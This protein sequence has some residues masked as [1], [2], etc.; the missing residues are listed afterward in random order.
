MQSSTVGP[1]PTDVPPA[2]PI[3]LPEFNPGVPKGTLQHDSLVRFLQSLHRP[4]ELRAAHFEALGIQ[5]H[6]EAPAE[7]VVPDAS[8]LPP[9]SKE[10]ENLSS[11]QA[12]AKDT[13]FRLDLSNGNKSPEARVYA[14][15]RNEL[16]TDN[17][18]AFRTIRRMR[19]EPGA[20]TPRLGHCYDFFTRLE[21]MASYWDDTSLPTIAHQ[22]E[23]SDL[24][25]KKTSS[26]SPPS[27]FD[28]GLKQAHLAMAGSEPLPVAALESD[29]RS[30]SKGVEE[31]SSWRVT[32]RTAAGSA[33]PPELRHGVISAFIK[34]VSYDFGC[35]ITAPRAE[36]RLHL[37]EPSP[38]HEPCSQKRPSQEP[39][40]SYFNSGCVFLARVPTKREAAR[41]GIVEGPL[42]AVSAR[43]TTSFS[44]PTENNVD[45]GR[46]IVAALIT[47]QHRAR[48]GKEERR[49]G[50][51]KWWAT[52]R[53]W[54]GA[55]GGPIGR[56]IEGNGEDSDKVK[57][58]VATDLATAATESSIST[59]KEANSNP[60]S[61]KQ[62][63]SS[64]STR[65]Q[66]P[67][68]PISPASGLP[69]RE[70][71]TAKKQRKGRHLS[72]YDNYRQ[73]RLPSST[74][75]KKTH[76]SAIGKT[77]GADYDDVFVI[78]SLFHHVSILRVRVPLKLLDVFAGAPEDNPSQRSW[79]KLEVWRSKWFDLFLAEERLEALRLLWGVNAWAMRVMP[80]TSE[81]TKN[82]Q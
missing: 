71:P 24:G 40:N 33:M 74:W 56:E 9:L 78:S 8:F 58:P 4:V 26:Q 48:E 77:P 32:Y 30:E 75:N 81:A 45:F 80:E 17:Q 13:G 46:E 14:E 21:A 70:A 55:E 28:A 66:S 34:L 12:S 16:L 68:K 57:S 18:L 19:P 36:P 37:L 82:R 22:D 47:A 50:E 35:N 15:R 73:V 38:T 3:Q 11:D 62:N 52:A 42:A 64:S 67:T 63:S 2:T 53:R 54:G 27:L 79:D 72:I 51:G 49:I 10:W 39:V 61:T 31:K 6:A 65:P 1:P 29:S 25:D 69:M 41:A 20:K 60:S 44:T 7:D 5:L 23:Q 76:Y 43:N 59:G